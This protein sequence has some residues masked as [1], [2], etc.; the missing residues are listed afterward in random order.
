MLHRTRGGMA[1]RWGE[2]SRVW[3][4]VQ[5]EGKLL[6]VQ[7]S[8]LVG[9]ILAG[10]GE[11]I[12]ELR[13][14]IQVEDGKLRKTGPLWLRDLA[15]CSPLALDKSQRAGPH[16]ALPLPPC[17]CASPCGHPL[18]PGGPG[19]LGC[20]SLPS[21][22][23]E[24][25]HP[26]PGRGELCTVSPSLSCRTSFLSTGMSHRAQGGKLFQ[27]H[28][29]YDS[30]EWNNRTGKGGVGL[31]LLPGALSVLNSQRGNLPSGGGTETVLG[32]TLIH[33]ALG[34]GPC[35]P[36]GRLVFR[37]GIRERQTPGGRAC[38]WVS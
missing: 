22:P 32:R 26:S 2:G 9:I 19:L 25:R 3:G 4:F 12:R 16:V 34:L 37:E 24:A 30:T 28:C 1:G 14:G 5:K 17:P 7:A 15:P 21:R 8:V 36:G 35:S 33:R 27:K 23:L 38:R 18:C 6:R 29:F 13:G 20:R 11:G 31:S 10:C